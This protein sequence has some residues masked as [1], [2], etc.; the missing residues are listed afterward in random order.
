MGKNI[1]YGKCY[2]DALVNG[3]RIEELKSVL[4][5]QYELIKK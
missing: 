3:L 5:H 2:Q 4:Y 1:H